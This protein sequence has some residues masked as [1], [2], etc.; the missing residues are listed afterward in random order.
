VGRA[1]IS[2]DPPYY[3]NVSYSDLSDFHYGWL[4]RGLRDIWPDELSTLS[5]PKRDELIAHQTRA[6]SRHAAT[7]HFEKGIAE[8]FE[9][10]AMAQDARFPV[11]IF[12]A[13]K[14]AET[15]DAGTA[16][17]GW[18]TFLSAPF[19]RCSIGVDSR[20]SLGATN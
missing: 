6:G 17:T 2:T 3:D 16:S 13:F 18:E 9:A 14:Q 15:D 8:V 12:Y 20:V 1:C 19:R 11:T 5:T 10:V 4:R 7:E